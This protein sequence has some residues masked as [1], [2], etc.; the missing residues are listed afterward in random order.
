MFKTLDELL[1]N[2]KCPFCE[3]SALEEEIV[4]KRC[5]SQIETKKSHSIFSLFWLSFS[6]LNRSYKNKYM[7]LLLRDHTFMCPYHLNDSCCSQIY[8]L[9]DVSF[10]LNHFKLYHGEFLKIY[11]AINPETPKKLA[12]PK[13]AD[14]NYVQIMILIIY[15]FHILGDLDFSELKRQLKE[16]ISE[17]CKN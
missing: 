9:Y 10:A 12:E 4:C 11:T 8:S 15:N 5:F 16:Q 14:L 1:S 7:N 3:S 2:N 13:I 6:E 17:L